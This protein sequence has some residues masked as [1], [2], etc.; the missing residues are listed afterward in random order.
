MKSV[1]I[2]G[3][4]GY[5]GDASH[6]T[7]Q[8]LQNERLDYLVYDYLAEVTM[9]IMARARGKDPD[10]GFAREFVTEAL[11]P[12]LREIASRGIRVISN[13]GGL[14]PYACA[15]AVRALL[16][17]KGLSLRVAVVTGDDLIQRK[18][19]LSGRNV[20]EMF[21][22]LPMPNVDRLVS[23]NAYLGGFPI[24]RVLEDGA[25]IVITGRCV[26]SAVTLGACIHA[27]GWRA[28]DLDLLAQGSLAGHLLECG[29][30]VT[31]GNFTDWR[32]VG[33]FA[34]IGY[35]LAEIRA[36]GVFSLFK[37]EGTAGVV[38]TL[39]VGEQMLYEIGDP[40]S[41]TLPDVVCDFTGVTMQS[42]GKDRVEVKGARGR[43]PTTTYKVSATYADGYRGGQL[44]SF[45]GF[46][47]RESAEAFA[48]AVFKRARRK[49]AALGIQDFDET[50]VE[51]VGGASGLSRGYEEVTL[52]I[53]ARHP[54][55]R[56]I[57]LM[58]KEA[59]ALGLSAPPGLS[60]F[61]AA[62]RAKASPV[63]RLFSFLIDKSEV[64]IAIDHGDGPKKCMWLSPQIA[65]DKVVAPEAPSVPAAKSSMVTVP[66]V[67]LAVAR[68]GDK[69]DSAN[70][71]VIARDRRFV[72]W[73]WD[74]LNEQALAKFFAPVLRGEVRR[75]YLP[76]AHAM[77][78]VF[79]EALGG[80]GI[81]SL[82]NDAQGKGFGQWVL[83]MPVAIPSEM[84]S[85]IQAEV[86][87]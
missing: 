70:V 41:Y 50:S 77:N 31:G 64:P 43:A 37:P 87:R 13:A 57:E 63:V 48:R 61:T 56:G 65:A 2:G 79:E 36:D 80:G 53:A 28:D 40:Q 75:Y 82:R 14:N 67:R 66:L 81:A 72:P 47:V 6:A 83:A 4:S 58:L 59:T 60:K 68:S 84:R 23:I 11:G 8:L 26:D 52:K 29:T 44:F 24:A 55:A 69:G 9:S 33:E 10:T 78:I 22:G 45:N 73:I 35:P 1:V 3:A 16:E 18:S 46:D 21:S 25:D 85:H 51:A 74:A 49:F 5:W 15:T 39:S 54:E 17:R 42:S 71:G 27:F 76:G 7:H 30:Q 32:E 34:D 38:S 20:K 86:V 19:E 12:N 62:G